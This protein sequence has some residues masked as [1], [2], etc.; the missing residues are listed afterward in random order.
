MALV[1]E[2]ILNDLLDRFEP[3]EGGLLS[4]LSDDPVERD[5]GQDAS[6][7]LND[8]ELQVV[9]AVRLLTQTRV[10]QNAE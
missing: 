4:N 2:D 8:L 9:L 5:E 6:A 3:K 7:E 1:G 10:E